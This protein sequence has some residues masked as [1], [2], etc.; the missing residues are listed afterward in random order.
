M[1]RALAQR[2]STRR[3]SERLAKQFQ[4]AGVAPAE[5]PVVSSAPIPTT[6]TTGATNSACTKA[7]AVTLPRITRALGRAEPGQE[8]PR[9]N[10]S[11]FESFDIPDFIARKR[12][13]T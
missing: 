6:G 7:S 11:P 12:V 10:S 4:S 9:T 13:G 8:N 3:K 2:T 1:T 5:A